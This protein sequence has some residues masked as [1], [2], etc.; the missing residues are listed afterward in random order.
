MK[1]NIIAIVL[2]L[3][4]AGGTY[5]LSQLFLAIGGYLQ[6]IVFVT[7]LGVFIIGVEYHNL[8][9]WLKRIANNTSM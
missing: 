6:I 2:G 4:L 8:G 7:V 3:C 1:R 5:G 9:K